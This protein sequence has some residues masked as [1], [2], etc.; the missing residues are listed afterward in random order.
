MT[1]IPV[2]IG[3]VDDHV[4]MRDAL[5]TVINT[6]DGFKVSLLAENGL[7]FIEKLNQTSRISSCSI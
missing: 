3:L 7:D 5:A 2:K 6:F 4:L 1:K